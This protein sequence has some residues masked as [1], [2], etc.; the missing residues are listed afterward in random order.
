MKCKQ[1]Q[2]CFILLNVCQSVVTRRMD[3]N[4]TDK[5]QEVFNF[6]LLYNLHEFSPPFPLYLNAENDKI[7][8][9]K[10]FEKTNTTTS[11]TIQLNANKV[12]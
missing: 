10:Y 1:I 8:V 7:P 4:P 3:H 9:Q 2:C 12:S 5:Y 11:P 6:N